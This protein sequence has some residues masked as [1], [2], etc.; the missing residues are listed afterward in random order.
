MAR[1]PASTQQEGAEPDRYG[2]TPHPRERFDL[3][4]HGEAERAFLDAWR[5]GRLHH[6]WLIGGPR[7]I[8]KAT[9]AYRVARFLLANP[10]PA[11]APAV[12]DLAVAPDH[13]VA[14]KVAALSHPDL[15]V[16]RR[17]PGTDKKGPSSTIAI[18]SVRRALAV[19]ASTAGAGGYR[20]CIVDSAEDLNVAS[21][22]ALLKVVEEPPPRSIFLIV[23]HSP[24]RVMA[25]IRSRCRKLTLGE[26][27]PD[28]IE[29]VVEGLGAPWDAIEPGLRARAA[30]LAQGSVQGALELLDEE[31]IALV[32]RVRA[33]LA[34]L[35]ALDMR[36]VLGLAELCA[37]RDGE[38]AFA[39]LM[40]TI[41]MFVTQTIH[42]RAAEGAAR[43]AP[44]VEVWEKSR[45]A[46]REAQV[47]NLD[48]RPLVLSIFN[49]LAG[50]LRHGE[51]A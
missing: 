19:F 23:S 2:L 48:R 3:V 20:I 36:E 32:E 37:G 10:D 9:F 33:M 17:T 47:L 22:N 11:A 30:A 49:D 51:A 26:L 27:A 12:R 41:D 15:V 13:P 42:A 34:R 4:G 39:A 43:L 5:A 18:D 46:A 21:A 35:P 44:L 28:E 45:G 16:L 38:E 7:G 29:T 24:G 25:T 6:A 50:A 40:A 31:R 1:E 8:G 14:R